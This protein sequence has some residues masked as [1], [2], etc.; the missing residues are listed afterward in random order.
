MN[1]QMQYT[2]V[3]QQVEDY[4]DSQVE[5]AII[6]DENYETLPPAISSDNTP[7]LGS[8]KPNP[9]SRRPSKARDFVYAVF[10]FLHFILV[11]VFSGTEDVELHDS[12][13]S[14]SSM[15]MVVTVLGCVMGVAAVVILSNDDL[16][17]PVY[18]HMYIHSSICIYRY[19]YIYTSTYVYLYIFTCICLYIYTYT[20]IYIY[21]RIYIYI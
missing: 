18:M 16:R 12:F 8:D 21:I 10:F 5:E 1:T 15:I 14:W 6:S 19:L 20:Y 2:R 3:S 4:D 11:S 9:F 13:N 17:E 7:V